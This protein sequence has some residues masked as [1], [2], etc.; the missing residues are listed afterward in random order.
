[1]D[2]ILPV[3]CLNPLSMKNKRPGGLDTP[4]QSAL[5]FHAAKIQ[6]FSHPASLSAKKLFFSPENQFFRTFAPAKKVPKGRHL[7]NPRPAQRSRG[8]TNRQQT[9]TINNNK[10]QTKKNEK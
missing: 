3:V 4:C 8:D 7:L 6:P 2:W 9:N 10:Q 5:Y 1:V